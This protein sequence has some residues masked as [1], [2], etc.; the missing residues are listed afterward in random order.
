[1]LYQSQ[2]QFRYLAA[3][4]KGKGK[5]N[6]PSVPL[7]RASGTRAKAGSI[8]P[9][10]VIQMRNETIE[11]PFRLKIKKIDFFFQ[12]T[13][14]VCIESSPYLFMLVSLSTSLET[15]GRR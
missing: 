5:K 7:Q 13:Y 12:F 9:N 2:L 3:L 15:E 11:S 6:L 4:T 10:W 14:Y 1:M 8:Q